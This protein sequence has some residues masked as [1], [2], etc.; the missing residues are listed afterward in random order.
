VYVL[1]M[2]L[3]HIFDLFF[4]AGSTIYIPQS[5][6][7]VISMI[8]VGFLFSMFGTMRDKTKAR[9]YQKVGGPSALEA[10]PNTDLKS[11]QNSTEYA[12]PPK[13]KV[14]TYCVVDPRLVHP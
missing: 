12:L 3:S 2:L 4:L 5:L 8:G 7:V 6:I 1:S 10:N 14:V 9:A 11:Y 13:Q